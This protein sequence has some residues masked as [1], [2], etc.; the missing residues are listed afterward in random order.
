MLQ[1]IDESRDDSG[2]EVEITDGGVN[3]RYVELRL[4]SK[5]GQNLE[6]LIMVYSGEKKPTLG[7]NN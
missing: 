2:G 7:N 4:N 6:Y 3:H 5:V 1:A